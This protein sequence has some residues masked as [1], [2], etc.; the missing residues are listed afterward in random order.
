[1]S[2]EQPARPGHRAAYASNW[3]QILAVDFG[4]GL[5]V[6]LAGLVVAVVWF[7]VLGGGIGALGGVYCW[8]VFRRYRQW[9]HWR[10]D[11]GLPG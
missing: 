5:V 7:P 10:R 9:Q 4:M 11:A 1:M 3:R 8:L 2:D 6:L